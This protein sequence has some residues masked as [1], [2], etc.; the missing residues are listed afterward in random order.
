[1]KPLP[2]RKRRARCS[3]CR[4]MFTSTQY[5]TR[6]DNKWHGGNYC[7]SCSNERAKE[8]QRTPSG[9]F[10]VCTRC[11]RGFEAS[12]IQVSKARHG[13]LTFCSKTCAENRNRVHPEFHLH[14]LCLAP[15]LG[16]CDRIRDWKT[17]IGR[18][19]V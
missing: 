13:R 1:M 10:S 18:A 15:V 3:A 4:V 2:K 14:P 9:T 5:R 11:R 19:H 17:K 12:N 16:G 7:P 6:G 8:W